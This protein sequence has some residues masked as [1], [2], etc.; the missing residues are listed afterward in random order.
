MSVVKHATPPLAGHS[1]PAAYS[2]AHDSPVEVAGHV[3]VSRTFAID[4]WRGNQKKNP[5]TDRSSLTPIH[6]GRV[7]VAFVN[8]QRPATIGHHNGRKS[9]CEIGARFR[10]HRCTHRI[11]PVPVHVTLSCLYC[12]SRKRESTVQP[13]HRQTYLGR[14]IAR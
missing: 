10:S 3:H 7:H 5:T 4:V 13:K 9:S 6:D 2:T 12:T 1:Y 11:R 8:S 14:S